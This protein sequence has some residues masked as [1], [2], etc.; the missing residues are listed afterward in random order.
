MNYSRRNFLKAAGVMSAGF[1]LGGNVLAEEQRKPNVVIIYTD[2]LGYGDVSCY[3]ATEIETPNIDRLAKQ[4]IRFTNT[5]TASATCTPSRYAL[6]TG[7]YPWRREDTGIAAGDANMI[8]E[9][10]RHT[11]PESMRNAGYKTAVVGKWHL[12]LGDSKIDWNQKIAPGPL[13]VGFDYSFIIPATG[14]RVPCVYVENHEVA[15]LDE[16]DPLYVSFKKPFEGLPTGKKNPELLDMKHSHGHN[17]A[18]IN[19]VGRIGY[20]KG[21][22]SAV[23]NDRTMAA[24]LVDKACNFM[25]RNRKKPFFL[26]FCTHDVHV[27]RLPNEEFRGKSGMGPRGDAI[28]QLD[29]TVGMLLDELEEMGLKD[30]TIVMFSSDNGPVLD[31]GYHDQAEEKLGDHEPWGPYRGN[32][33]SRYQA[34]TLVPFILRWPGKAPAGKTSD[35]LISQTDLFASFAAMNNQKM[36]KTA[37]DSMNVLPALLGKTERARKYLAVDSIGGLAVVGGRWKFMPANKK[38]KTAWQTG[39]DTGARRKPQLYDLKKDMAEKNNLADKMPDKT[40]ELSA[41]L[42]E[43]LNGAAPE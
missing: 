18:I 40:K 26:Y 41:K 15:N 5:H 4:G 34:G 25:H 17:N 1:A 6:L 8:I 11:W 35:A 20:M 23:W 9:A 10:G 38:P 12:G 42:E 21:G 39:I 29:W 37:P 19:G 36:P 13:E 3:G 33:Y 22:A 14:D 31:D 24:K 28:L 2:D 27:P 16:D 32:K 30:D 7:E 43:I